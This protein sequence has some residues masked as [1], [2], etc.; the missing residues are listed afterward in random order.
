M[1]NTISLCRGKFVCAAPGATVTAFPPAALLVGIEPNPGPPKKRQTKMVVVTPKPVALITKPKKRVKPSRAARSGSAGL[2]Q[3]LRSALNPFA[4]APPKLGYD[5]FAGSSVGTLWSR[6]IGLDP[7]GSFQPGTSTCFFIEFCPFTLVAQSGGSGPAA[8]SPPCWLRLGGSTLSS[9]NIGTSA[10][11]LPSGAKNTA[12]YLAAADSHRV[13]TAAV[14]ATVRYPMTSAPGRLFG[15]TL[16]ESDTILASLSYNGVAGLPTAHPIPFDGSGVAVHQQNWRQMDL[17]SFQYTNTAANF[18][19]GLN[20]A[21]CVIV[22][23]GWPAGVTV[24]IDAVAHTEFQSGAL[25]AEVTDIGSD[26]SLSLTV[27]RDVLGNQIK[28]VPMTLSKTDI[29]A[30]SGSAMRAAM[31][32]TAAT[33]PQRMGAHS[34]VTIEEVVESR[35]SGAGD[36]MRDYVMPAASAA[37][38]IGAEYIIRRHGPP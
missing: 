38:S 14:R 16:Y 18:N 6:D 34:T 19:G 23:V 31:I 11:S 24:D 17:T 37:A 20:Y 13:L 8:G 35:S 7:T 29:L 10:F 32:R 2:S 9:S 36:I 1:S 33:R 15:L 22:G 25:S 30:C 21:K 5:T 26:V 4:Y 28:T 3:F 27:P 12:A